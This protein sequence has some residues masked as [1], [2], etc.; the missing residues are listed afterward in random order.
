MAR[1]SK[2]LVSYRI[3]LV[4]V[5]PLL[6]VITGAAV[7]GVSYV[8]SRTN[9][10]G[11]AASL[12]AQVAAQTAEDARSHVQQAVPAADLVAASIAASDQ[13]LPPDELARRLLPVLRANP[14][15]SWVSF[16]KPDGTFTGVQRSADGTLRVNESR[17][18]DGRTVLDERVVANNEAWVPHRQDADTHYDPRA[19]PFYRQ[20]IAARRRVW[21]DPYLFAAPS[22][23]VVLGITC[24]EPVLDRDGALRG[25]VTVDF[26]FAALSDF[27][28]TLHASEHARVFVY[29]SSGVLLAHPDAHVVHPD[30]QTVELVTRDSVADPALRAYFHG[31]EDGFSLDGARYFAS[32]L[33]FEPDP[34][35]HW[36]VGAVAP[37]SDFMGALE[38]AIRLVLVISLAV[39]VIAVVVAFT[40]ARHI[41][42]PLVHLAGEMEQVG[43]FELGGDDLPTSRY[44]EIELMNQALARMRK[45]LASFAV[46]VPRDL[47]RAVLAS[48]QRAELGGHTRPMSIFFS[49]LAGFTSLS[50]RLKPAA[51]VE[52]LASYFDQ[53]STVISRHH[54][55][56][57][58]FIGDAIMAFWNAPM[59]EPDH[60]VLACTC[61]LAFQEKLDEMKRADP[62][63]AELSARIGIATGDV[64]VG[65]IGSHDRM[66]YT[67]M[68]DTVNL[69]SRLE[70][71]GKEYGAR[72]LISEACAL[73]VGDRVI[74]RVVDVVA[75]KGKHEGVRVYEPLALASNADDHARA[76]ADA[77][78]RGMAAY[79]ARQ[80][81][82]AIAAYDEIL[83]RVPDDVAAATLRARSTA[84][85]AAP[86][87]EG[88][89]GVHVMVT[90]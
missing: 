75:V 49:D 30:A 83:A 25:V 64:V 18:V 22:G 1:R 43:R 44:R 42:R 9:I 68:G 11:L 5:V 77:S 6:V 17:I 62:G 34:G 61:A 60:A 84:Y 90:K 88:W 73:A 87:P 32:T 38:R 76:I 20:A 7:A 35:L 48:G 37:E 23:R 72:I 51:L 2:W 26:D 4:V 74:T 70:G 59:A 21:T 71:L 65:N 69:A 78:T 56:I 16:S 47:V 52:L 39:V 67:V 41:A 89:T 27:V 29:T 31:G 14:G 82:V 54:G 57:D 36:S 86:P 55:T 45:G 33:A 15:F 79:L 80:W 12:F 24:A 8:R 53:M 85:A 63:L 50:E 3:S 66:N 19:R 13:T 46:Y 40:F 81:T 58:K 28:D 10:R